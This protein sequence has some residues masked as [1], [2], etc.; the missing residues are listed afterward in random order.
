M[1]RDKIERAYNILKSSGYKF[2]KIEGGAKFKSYGD[3]FNAY[4]TISNS[5]LGITAAQNSKK[6]Y[7]VEPTPLPQGNME[8]EEVEELEGPTDRRVDLISDPEDATSLSVASGFRLL[9]SG[10]KFDHGEKFIVKRRK[11]IIEGDISNIIAALDY[12]IIGYER[13][14]NIVEKKDRVELRYLTNVPR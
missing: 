9:F 14:L 7:F 1:N 13:F 8:W 11:M 12:F 6:I 3:A 2:K 4:L 5:F 10:S